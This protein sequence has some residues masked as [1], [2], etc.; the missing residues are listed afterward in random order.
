[1]RN[2]KKIVAVSLAAALSLATLSG[3]TSSGGSAGGSSQTYNFA[4]QCAWGTGGGP[5]QY[6]S[7][8]S[9]AIVGASGGRVTMECLAA[10]SIVP[11]SDMLTAV[12]N[13][14][15]DCAQT[16]AT[17]FSDDSL[18][19]LSTL[20]VGMTFDEYMGWYIAGEG[21]QVL[22]EVMSEIDSNVVAFPCGVVDSEILYHSTKPITSIDD[23]KGLKIRAVS[24]WANIETKLG[25]S[26]VNMDGGDCYEALSR[27]T[28]DACEYSS[29]SANWAAGFQE[30]APY[31]TVPGVHQ[32]CA[33]YLF[34]MNR[35]VWD[36]LDEQVQ[37]IIKLSCTA[38]MAQNW[39]EDRVANGAAWQQFEELQEQGK[40]TIYQLPEKDLEKI[41][42]VADEYYA[43]KCEKNPLF[44]KIY[45]SQKA[46]VESVS[47][48]SEAA[49]A[50]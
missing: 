40:L 18:G 12:S 22:D 19:I 29:P 7:D 41:Q 4:Y 43:E 39:A 3:C 9:N 26:V 24:D 23:I 28:I 6:A 27:G 10:N 17:N 34:L 16:A 31:M 36:G 45:E 13:G 1:M 32:S 37:N 44:A 38:M 15:L 33:V 42:T 14:T 50:K 21:Q 48:W 47:D 49:T 46:Y 30:V 5:F 20:P 2:C 25:A 11:A 8:L 35:N